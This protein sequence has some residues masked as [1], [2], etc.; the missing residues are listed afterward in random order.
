MLQYTTNELIAICQG[1]ASEQHWLLELTYNGT[2]WGAALGT[3]LHP[4]VIS[5]TP[6]RYYRT[7]DEALIGLLIAYYYMTGESIPVFLE[8]SFARIPRALD[9]G[10]LP[11]YLGSSQEAKNDE[12]AP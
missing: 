11:L 9:I 5:A 3:P 12:N 4:C 2:H 1:I 10:R 6:D 7:V 8:E